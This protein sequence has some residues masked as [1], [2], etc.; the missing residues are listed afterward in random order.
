MSVPAFLFKKGGNAWNGFKGILYKSSNKLVQKNILWVLF[1][2][3]GQRRKQGSKCLS[4]SPPASCPQNI[5]ADLPDLK[6]E[7]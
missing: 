3:K 2:K 7:F 6:A 1:S 4:K 5:L